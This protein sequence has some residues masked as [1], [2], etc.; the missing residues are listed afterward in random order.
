MVR[1]LRLPCYYMYEGDSVVEGEKGTGG[2]RNRLSYRGKGGPGA[3]LSAPTA[4]FLSLPHPAEAL[5]TAA[6]AQ[7]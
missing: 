2:G 4:S 1:N 7:A 6:A 5:A 3:L